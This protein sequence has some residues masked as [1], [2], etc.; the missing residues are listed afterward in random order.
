MDSPFAQQALGRPASDMSPAAD[1][2]LSR[3]GTSARIFT[4]FTVDC[5]RPARVTVLYCVSRRTLSLTGVTT[6][7]AFRHAT[8]SLLLGPG[9]NQH[10]CP[11][12]IAQALSALPPSSHTSQAF[13]LQ[14]WSW[15][16]S[17]SAERDC[18]LLFPPLP[19]AEGEGEAATIDAQGNHDT[20]LGKYTDRT[21]SV[22]ILVES[23]ED[24]DW[25]SGGAAV[26][27]VPLPQAEVQG[28][29]T[30]QGAQI[31]GIQKLDATLLQVLP[32]APPL[33]SPLQ[34]LSTSVACTAH[35]TA[36]H[37]GQDA[38]VEESHGT[39]AEHAVDVPLG[40]TWRFSCSVSEQQ[41][42]V[43]GQSFE[44]QEIYGIDALQRKGHLQGDDAT[45]AAMDD[46]ALCLICLTE[47]RGVMMLPCRHVCL[48]S[49]CAQEMR[50]HAAFKCPVCRSD[51]HTLMQIREAPA[52][53]PPQ[54]AEQGGGSLK[55]ADTESVAGGGASGAAAAAVPSTSAGIHDSAV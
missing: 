24:V 21:S 16:F 1:T 9:L 36:L 40:D 32:C 52:P 15:D 12:S 25:S 46:D 29:N 54:P 4:C 19:P 14:D 27:T 5:D 35:V 3:T 42:Q 7:V 8:P 31:T 23:G 43:E 13:T 53:H 20:P 44:L 2:E 6:H 45:Q 38:A 22:L 33:G 30:A 41:L 18:R 34:V 48:C 37:Q 11:Q 47:S 28:G 26:S 39:V 17:S 10:I 51:V 49:G 50:G 55:A